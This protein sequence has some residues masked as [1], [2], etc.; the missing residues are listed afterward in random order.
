M[1]AMRELA[2]VHAS[3]P[4]DR[5]LSIDEAIELR[6][7]QISRRR[8]LQGAGVLGAAAVVAVPPLAALARPRR[9]GAHD[10]RVVVVGPASPVSPARTSCSSTVSART[11][12]KHVTVSAA[13]AGPHGR[14]ATAKWPST[15]GSS[16]TRGTRSSDG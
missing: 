8:L 10:P 15:A 9:H 2:E 14:S 13:V 5:A 1:R 3:L 6:N 7:R 11:S 4:D 16:W 12:T